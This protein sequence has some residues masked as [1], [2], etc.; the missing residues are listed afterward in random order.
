MAVSGNGRFRYV[1]T[2]LPGSGD[3]SY[4]FSAETVR[5][6]G[7]AYAPGRSVSEVVH[8]TP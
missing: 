2:F 1:Y 3:A 5:E 7:Y 8:V 4:P 6:S